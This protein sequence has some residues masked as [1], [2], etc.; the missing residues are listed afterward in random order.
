MGHQ[1]FGKQHFVAL[2]AA[3]GRLDDNESGVPIRRQS[4][5]YTQLRFSG[6]PNLIWQSPMPWG[7]DIR[8]TPLSK[9]LKKISLVLP[10]NS[11]TYTSFIFSNLTEKSFLGQIKIFPVKRLKENKVYNNFNQ[12]FFEIKNGKQPFGPNKILPKNSGQWKFGFSRA[13][14]DQL[15]K[16]ACLQLSPHL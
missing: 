4:G 7:N 14:G 16:C 6:M 13:M 12:K 2:H 5:G 11:F 15:R 1:Q 9:P 10:Q 8:V 3:P